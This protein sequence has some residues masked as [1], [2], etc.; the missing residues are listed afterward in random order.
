MDILTLSN[1]IAVTVKRRRR[2]RA[3]RLAV[4]PGGVVTLTLPFS[5]PLWRGQA[6]VEGKREWIAEKQRLLAKHRPSLLSLGNK[7]EYLTHKERARKHILGRLHFYQ[8]RYL[9]FP[10]SISIR[11]QKTRFGSCSPLRQLS[12]NYQLLF[13]PSEL[14]DYVVVHELCHLKEMNHSPR[15]WTLVSQTFPD[16][17][18]LRREL[19]C[20]TRDV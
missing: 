14:C 19:Q 7:E 8:G 12:F 15:F 2:L 9:L 13:L 10:K 1:G 20:F 18:R 11:N 16:Y 17:R 5:L 3:L 6:F 4:L